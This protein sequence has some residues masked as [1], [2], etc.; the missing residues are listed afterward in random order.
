MHAFGDVCL[1]W[2]LLWQANIADEK[3]EVI[4]QM[5]CA[6]NDKIKKSLI[7]HNK[8]ATV[9]VGKLAVAKHFMSNVLPVTNGRINA[10]NNEEQSA[11]DIAVES[12][13]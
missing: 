5:A 2:A 3:L 8:D 13:L 12:F 6:A 11:W 9:Y 10:I 7:L 1:A 4:R